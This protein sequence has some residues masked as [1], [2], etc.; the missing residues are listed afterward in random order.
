MRPGDIVLIFRPKLPARIARYVRTGKSGKVHV[1]F[2]D[3]TTRRY[4]AQSVELGIR[5][6]IK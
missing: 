2:R 3:G 5:A 6:N 4:S 1:R